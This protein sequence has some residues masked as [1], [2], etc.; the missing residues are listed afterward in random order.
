MLSLIYSPVRH[1]GINIS[2]AVSGRVDAVSS[3]RTC[4]WKRKETYRVQTALTGEA[5]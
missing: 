2:A 4:K 5:S 3:E 1:F